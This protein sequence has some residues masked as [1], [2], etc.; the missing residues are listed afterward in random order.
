VRR[1][2]ED[3]IEINIDVQAR[4][5]LNAMQS[6][7]REA[8]K[9]ARATASL[10][11]TTTKIVEVNS[12]YVGVAVTSLAG[13]AA[14]YV[15]IRMRAEET[16][17]GIRALAGAYEQ[18]Q[19]AT[20]G[21]VSATEALSARQQLLD[22]GLQ[23]TADQLAA[24][25][26][27]AVDYS[28]AT[29]VEMSEAI[30]AVTR[31]IT[32]RHGPAIQQL[33]LHINGAMTAQQ[34]M[35]AMTRDMGARMAAAGP[36][37]RTLAEDLRMLQDSAVAIGTRVADALQ[38]AF[39]PLHSLIDRI[40]GEGTAASIWRELVTLGEADRTIAQQQRSNAI[41]ERRL[42]ARERLA[43]MG[44]RIDPAQLR[45]MSVEELERAAATANADTAREQIEVDRRARARAEAE[46]AEAERLRRED[47]AKQARVEAREG[48]GVRTD[49][50]R[51]ERRLKL[52]ELRVQV[53]GLSE[54]TALMARSFTE[55]QTKA[56]QV[57]NTL[58]ITARTIEEEN[59]LFRSIIDSIDE[60]ERARA[61]EQRRVVD[62]REDVF[63]K[64]LERANRER[65]SSIEG[66]LASSLGVQTS[67]LEAE[68]RATQ[69]YA[70][71]ITSAYQRMT[72]AITQHVEAVVTGQETIGQ[73]LL[74]AVADVT[75]A[76][77]REALP[78]SLM[79]LAAGLAALANPVT[80]ATAPLHFAAS[81]VYAAIAAGAGIVGAGAS[82][83]SNAMARRPAVPGVVADA[84]AASGSSSGGGS[85]SGAPVTIVISSITPPGPRELSDLVR[86]RDQA[87]RYGL[88]APRP[89]EVRT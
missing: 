63:A 64:E 81:G 62:Q 3:R 12:R 9:T 32:E 10:S 23:P 66:R 67:S 54:V 41:A 80:A 16:E 68:A 58:G 79:E 2:R 84:R 17:R 49:Q 74:G 24:V 77:A 15:S 89:R 87:G 29:G 11:E 50:F 22:A 47:E 76:L 46:R 37:V 83:A 82:A 55:L 44:V 27:A 61:E 20:N 70:D 8:Q 4:Q 40:H 86:A 88:D 60:R 78:R 85:S 26:R 73:A 72:G 43:R 25:T 1:G 33:G 6:V 57:A 56:L 65:E 7:Q 19:V 69:Q 39:A 13:L 75:L 38:R 5:A 51:E 71:T 36:P 45:S 35:N 28:R 14:A 52:D 31:A 18:V 48:K 30:N 59:D 42:Q 53:F 34:A 21:A